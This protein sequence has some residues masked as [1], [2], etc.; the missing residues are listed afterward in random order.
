MPGWGQVEAL[1]LLVVAPG[2]SE[3]SETIDR[4][5]ECEFYRPVL[6]AFIPFS[7]ISLYIFQMPLQQLHDFHYGAHFSY[8]CYSLYLTF[9]SSVI[10]DQ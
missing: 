5:I 1:L 9:L 4:G 10:T 7:R 3:A 2:G 6:N 8:L